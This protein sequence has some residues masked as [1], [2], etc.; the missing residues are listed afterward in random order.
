M[1]GVMLVRVVH[2]ASQFDDQFHCGSDRHWLTLEDCIEWSAH[3]QHHAE[4]TSAI[5]LADFINWNDAWMVQSGG[6]FRFASESFHVRFRRPMTEGDDLQC[7]DAIETFLT[8]AV[9]HALAASTDY[10]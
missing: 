2:R 5:T 8:G 10:F 9:N 1:Q 4:V 3:H 7:H 6:R